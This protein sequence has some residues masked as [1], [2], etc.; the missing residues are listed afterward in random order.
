MLKPSKPKF[1]E[2]ESVQKNGY[3]KETSCSLNNGY[4]LNGTTTT[5]THTF[6]DLIPKTYYKKTY[7]H[8]TPLPPVVDKIKAKANERFECNHYT[9]AIHLYNKAIAMCPRAAVLFGNRA[10]AYM[11]RK[12]EGDLYAAL[13]DCY[14]SLAID[15]DYFKAHYRLVRCLHDLEWYR[16][17]AD[18][19]EGFKNKFPDQSD[20][21]LCKGLN[22]DI[23][24]AI[25]SKSDRSHSPRNAPSNDSNLLDSNNGYSHYNMANAAN[26]Q[27]KEWRVMSFDY[28]LRYCG[29][30]NTTTDIKEANFFGRHDSGSDFC[31]LLVT[32]SLQ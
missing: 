3:H 1:Y 17:A 29:H 7:P 26:N 23:Q 25:G 18:C 27:E 20:N 31:P 32:L 22:K 11:K 28:K 9:F 16:E 15:P 30:C 13:R 4:H 19:F 10:M 5:T 12:W 24:K 6:K 21:E 8:K 2:L 14:T